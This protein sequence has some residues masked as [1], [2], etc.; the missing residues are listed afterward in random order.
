MSITSQLSVLINLLI[1]QY[2]I[3]KFFHWNFEGE[4]F[5]S[6]HQL[7]DS[8]ANNILQSQDAI[9]EH[10]RSLQSKV[11][12]EPEL[13]PLKDIDTNQKNLHNILNL[14]ITQHNQIIV[15]ITEIIKL[16]NFSEDFGTSDILTKYLEEQQK[17][18]WFIQSSNK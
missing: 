18:L 12:V 5:Y 10:V 17:M 15:E 14:I 3:Y 2:F 13:T 1:N 9:A 7:F 16:A 11:S 6:Y 4:D 8:H